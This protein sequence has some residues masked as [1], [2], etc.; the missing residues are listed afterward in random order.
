MADSP[1]ISFVLV[2][3]Q[4]QISD[5]KKKNVCRM[6]NGL[7]LFGGFIVLK[8]LSK[9]SVYISNLALEKVPKKFDRGIRFIS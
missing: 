8:K 7:Y 9:S 1:A 4:L 2:L 5:L 3:G 6:H